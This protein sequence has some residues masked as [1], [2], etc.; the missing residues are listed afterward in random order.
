MD[1]SRNGSP[2]TGQKAVHGARLVREGKTLKEAAEISNSTE[3]QIEAVIGVLG[4]VPEFEQPLADAEMTLNAALVGAGYRAHG[5]RKNEG[6]MFGKGDLWGELHLRV[7]QYLTAWARK[8]WKF[9]HVPPK[10]AEKRIV[11]IDAIIE[12]LQCARADL[13]ARS[14]RA[15]SALSNKIT[16]K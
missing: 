14:V 16:N 9:T 10:E 3:R 4:R 15:T 13:V 12:G 8:D 6:R 1:A 5:P 11:E 7:M 2:T